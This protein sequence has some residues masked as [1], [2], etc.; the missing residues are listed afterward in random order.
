[1]KNRML[2]T[3]SLTGGEGFTIRSK[4]LT[5]ILEDLCRSIV[6]TGEI[7]MKTRCAD[8][9]QQIDFLQQMMYAK[10]QQIMTLESKLQ[11]ASDELTKIVNTKVFAKGNSVIFELDHTQRQ[12]RL[13]KDNIF[14]MESRLKESV[15]QDFAKDLKQ[16][17]LQLEEEKKKFDGYKQVLNTSMKIEIK[18][19][20][21]ELDVQLKK[22]INKDSRKNVFDETKPTKQLEEEYSH[23]LQKKS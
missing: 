5:G 4:D 11:H 8:L 7:E 16:A 9:I 23:L 17:Q 19:H 3:K 14:Q 15:R 10:D 21:N 12:L 18:E 1:M 6:K 20:I 22:I 2:V 13:I